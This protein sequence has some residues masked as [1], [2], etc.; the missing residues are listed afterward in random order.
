MIQMFHVTKAFGNDPPTLVDINLNIEKAEFVFLTGPSGAGKSTLL[1]LI[2][3]AERATR[4][5]VLVALEVRII[6]TE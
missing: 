4:G 2:F 3:L 5:K 1:K 6:A